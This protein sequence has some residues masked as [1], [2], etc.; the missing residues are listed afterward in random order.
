MAEI[1]YQHTRMIKREFYIWL[2]SKLEEHGWQNI[3]SRAGDFEVY[4]SKGISGE[5]ELY[6]QM[7]EFQTSPTQSITN[8]TYSNLMLRPLEKYVPSETPGNPG[9]LTPSTHLWSDTRI[10][11]GTFTDVEVDVWY[12]CDADKITFIVKQ[13]EFLGNQT[14]YWY[15]GKPD[16]HAQG[17]LRKKLILLTSF[18]DDANY[19]RLA[20]HNSYVTGDYTPTIQYVSPPTAMNSDKDMFFMTQL[21]F[22]DAI[23]GYFCKIDGVCFMTWDAS[24]MS[25]QNSSFDGH[26]IDTGDGRKY[27]TVLL[28][29]A[30]GG[31]QNI[32]L[33]AM[34]YRV[35]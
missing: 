7:K 5:E 1:I 3:S 33:Y 29:A 4:H 8:S 18:V 23:E 19:C 6:F 28:R 13:P 9:V 2:K 10:T 17:N 25:H 30:A 34:A 21:S 22:Y 16:Y 31:W 20:Y 35:E 15:I 32:P 11:M 12:Y 27:R 14:Y 24:V 26:T